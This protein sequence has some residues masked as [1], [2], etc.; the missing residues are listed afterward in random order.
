MRVRLYIKAFKALNNYELDDDE[1]MRYLKSQARSR[2]HDCDFLFIDNEEEMVR[3][4][5]HNL[6]LP[7]DV[8][9]YSWV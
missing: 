7:A 9:Q 8:D 1:V 3:R 4:E 5:Q 6:K 2:T